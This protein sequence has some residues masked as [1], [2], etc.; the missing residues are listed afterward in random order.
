MDER[1]RIEK[2]GG[3]ISNFTPVARVMWTREVKLISA[4]NNGPERR[5]ETIPFLSIA[6]S[7]GD[8]WSYVP[9]TDCYAVSPVPDCSVR[10]IDL[11]C[12]KYLVLMSDGIT[13]VMSSPMIA[14]HVE[15][16]KTVSNIFD[17]CFDFLNQTFLGYGPQHGSLFVEILN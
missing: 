14:E 4:N 13:N 9:E 6:R 5:T 15:E 17:N 7:L 16:W 12:D 1:L 11:K 3:R 10:P 8:Y 2:D